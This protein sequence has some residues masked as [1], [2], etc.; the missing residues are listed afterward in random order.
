MRSNN[1]VFTLAMIQIVLAVVFFHPHAWAQC[2]TISA[3]ASS[4]P[5]Q[6]CQGSFT[7]IASGGSNYQWYL[8]DPAM[9]GT[10]LAAAATYAPTQSGTYYLTGKNSCNVTQTSNLPVTMYPQPTVPVV[11]TFIVPYNTPA[12]LQVEGARYPENY[13]WYNYMHT[14]IGTG[15]SKYPVTLTANTTYMVSKHDNFCESDPVTFYV[16]VDPQPVVTAA[17]DISLNVPSGSVLIQASASD[18]NENNAAGTL[19]YSWRKVS[20]PALSTNVDNIQ[21]ASFTLSNMPAG[22]YVFRITVKDTFGQTASDDIVVTITDPADVSNNYTFTRIEGINTP[23]ITSQ[24]Q[25]DALAIDKKDV[26]LTYVNG[27]GKPM[28]IVAM[29][30]SPAKGDVIQPVV[31]DA[32]GRP[33]RGYLPVVPNVIGDGKYEPVLNTLGEYAGANGV[34]TFYS[35]KPYAVTKFETSPLGRVIEEGE[36]GQA[37]QPGGTSGTVKTSYTA[38][39]PNDVREWTINTAT[40]PTGLPQSTGA[41]GSSFLQVTTFTN[42]VSDTKQVQRQVITDSQ[43]LTLLDRVNSADWAETYYVYDTRGNTRF[44]ITPSLTKL[45]KTAGNYVPA[46]AEVD[47]WCFQYLYDGLNRMIAGKGPGTDWVYFVYDKR[48]RIVLIQDGNQRL[49]NSWSFVKYDEY[50]RPVTTGIYAPSTEYTRDQLQAKVNA[51][52]GGQGYQNAPAPSMRS[53]V[54]IISSAYDGYREY[55]ASNSVVLQPGFSVAASAQSDFRASIGNGTSQND[56]IFPANEMQNM[57]ATYYDGYTSNDFVFQNP[58]FLFETKTWPANADADPYEKFD[59]LKGQVTGVSTRV[60]NS[61][62]WLHTVTYYDRKQRPIQ[63]VSSTLNGGV[64]RYATRYDFGSKLLDSK[65]EQLSQTIAKRFIYDHKGRLLKAFHKLNSQ[66]EVLLSSALY[67]EQGQ[68]IDKRLH[69]LD[70]GATNLQSIDYTYN[71]HGLITKANNAAQT[72]AGETDYFAYEAAYDTDP[73]GASSTV[74]KDGLITA[75]KWR[76]NFATRQNLYSYEYDNMLRINHSNYKGGVNFA[77]TS[78]T[79]FYSEKNI[80]YD[81][82]GNIQ[83]LKRY[84]QYDA[85]STQ[86]IDDLGYNYGSSSGNQLLAVTENSTAETKHIGFNDGNLSGN[87]FAYDKNGNVTFDRNKSIA[88]I[89]YNFLNL[90]EVVTFNDGARLEYTYDAAGVKLKQLQFDAAGQ[91]VLKT[92]YTGDQVI[93]NDAPSIIFHDEGRL[94]PPSNTNLIYNREANGTEGYAAKNANIVISSQ[95]TGGQTYVKATCNAVSV[96]PGVWPINGTK[97]TSG[98]IDVLPGESYSFKILGYQSAGTSAKLYTWMSNGSTLLGNALPSGLANETWVTQAI[99]I[100]AGVTQIKVGVLWETPAAGNIFYINRAALYKSDWEYQY[101]LSDHTGSARA[102]LSSDPSVV[103]YTVTFET[104]NFSDENQ[105]LLNID[106]AKFVTV[107]AAANAT[108]GG[109]ES[110]SMNNTYRIGPAKSLRVYPGDKVDASVYSYYTSAAGMTKTPLSTMAT[111]LALVM[112]GG[113]PRIDAGIGTAYANSGS[114][115]PGF[116]LSADQGTT[117]PSA[118]LNYILFDDNYVPLQAKSVPVVGMA[119][120]LQLNAISQVSVAEPGYLFIYLSYDNENTSPVYFDDLKIKH[121]ESH[122]V[123][124][125]DYYPFGLTSYSWIREGEYENRFLFQQKE[126]EPKTGLHD[127]ETRQYDAA[128]GRFMGAD[129]AGQFSSPYVGMGN[130]PM[131]GIDPNGMWFGYDDVVVMA[132]GLVY[133]YLSYG[134]THDEWG[135]DAILNG[136]LYMALFEVTYLT[137]G[138]GLEAG[139]STATTASGSSV[140]M[141]AA[142][143]F[144]LQTAVQTA[145][146]Y[147]LP[148]YPVY[149]DE[150]FAI[151]VS[152]TLGMTGGKPSIGTSVNTTWRNGNWSAGSNLGVGVNAN[153]TNASASLNASYTNGNWTFGASIAGK[154]DSKEPDTGSASIRATYTERNLSLGAT[155]GLAFKE[156]EQGSKPV[157]GWQW[158]Y[159]DGRVMF[160][161]AE[162]YTGGKEPTINREIR[163]AKEGINIAVNSSYKVGAVKTEG[164]SKFKYSGSISYRDYRADF[165]KAGRTST[166]VPESVRYKHFVM[167]WDGVKALLKKVVH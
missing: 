149:Q 10:F 8:G 100:P 135:G 6:A 75:L 18:L 109:N 71:I 14:I 39:A 44:I 131:N 48:D 54:D 32:L 103:P 93:I 134:L 7:L 79:D 155:A 92:E 132:V 113:V 89:T 138:G 24:A 125:N 31:Y 137:S 120:A 112:S 106:P 164:N 98:V 101:I 52:S 160:G 27:L 81:P 55:Q 165:S 4:N 15:R 84:K 35:D 139:A 9:G 82:N 163:Y 69:S 13:R 142:G 78:N 119:A 34:G 68:V 2:T 59:R 148:A 51:L 123:Q 76:N 167:D 126:H 66:P 88:S 157:T 23:G 65:L 153:G 3:G 152:P 45:L 96:L 105:K 122:L 41:W 116:L 61:D 127:F 95:V 108:P 40:V 53:G 46:Q 145:A 117:K 72:D 19:T 43:G 60:L 97:N 70:D 147:I 141:E 58:A 47:R 124:V 156:G 166:L 104:E 21:S 107:P 33:S 121:T 91:Q 94:L 102:V 86:L 146:S 83:A 151:S 87:D 12:F 130:S 38:N 150:H 111:A 11:T 1:N 17:A 129:P 115:L 49:A 36:T 28:E 154:N 29:Q 114:A 56:G 159:A 143:K 42:Y 99:T 161:Y 90:P 140:A 158:N 162:T 74:R 22:Q 64:T 50:D 63:T 85:V 73:Y 77:W 26:Q 16:K 118:F 57:T 128:L 30:Q 25:A 133:G 136:L 67:N 144:L 5:Y 20:G 37:W 62:Q 110:I 80:T